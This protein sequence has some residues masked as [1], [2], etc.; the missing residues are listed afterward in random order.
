MSITA[1]QRALILES[2]AVGVDLPRAA[3]GAGVG[4]AAVRR[5]MAEEGPEGAGLAR[6]VA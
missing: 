2:L 1:A 4:V 3:R 5:A 6:D